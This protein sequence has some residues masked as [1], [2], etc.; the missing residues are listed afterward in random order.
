[1]TVY[2]LVLACRRQWIV[3]PVGLALTF[4]ILWRGI[5]PPAVYYSQANIV[6]FVPASTRYPN[7]LEASSGSLIV[8][9]GNLQQEIN[10][11]DRNLA[12]ASTSVTLVDQGEYRRTLVRVPDTGGQWSHNFPQPVLDVQVTGQDP[13]FVKT[14]MQ[15][16]INRI[17]DLLKAK[18]I[19]AKVAQRNLIRA[20]VSPPNPAVY[21]MSG[22]PKAA[23]AI[24]AVIG[25]TLT[26]VS[27][28]L[29]DRV[30]TR[31]RQR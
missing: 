23:G 17:T 22:D 15:R 4:L 14:E 10:R 31:V 18:Q 13:A 26:L 16:C 12:A 27:A 6:L 7:S 21:R 3:L 2:D 20:R 5:A 29:L 19:E 24:G 11:S 1:M 9:A 28:A 25:L 30:R 8:L